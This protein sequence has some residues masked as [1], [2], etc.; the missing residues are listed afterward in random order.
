MWP[1]SNV[2]TL[3]SKV[4]IDQQAHNHDILPEFARSNR[5]R[6][7]PTREYLTEDYERFARDI[8]LN[9][10]N[11]ATLTQAVTHRSFEHGNVRHMERL[12][13][14]GQCVIQTFAAEFLIDKVSAEQLQ[15]RIES[16]KD[17]SIVGTIGKQIGLNKLLR[18]VPVNL[19]EVKKAEASG[20]YVKPIGQKHVT[21]RAML[22]LVGAIYHDQGAFAA[23]SFFHRHILP[24]HPTDHIFAEK[25]LL[26]FDN[27]ILL[28]T[29]L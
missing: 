24:R 29:D 19:E 15:T 20:S 22:A 14:L 23:K 17:T 16:Y 1:I 26:Q 9:F 8:G 12:E 3:S 6:E 27:S 11:P 18:W 28:K 7:E 4:A 21:G 10:S 25:P 2:K 5:Y 13:Y